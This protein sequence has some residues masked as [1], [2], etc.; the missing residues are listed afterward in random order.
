MLISL[1]ISGAWAS[2][3][4]PGEIASYLGVPCTPVCTVCHA[5]NS[6]GSGT[7]TQAFGVAMEDRGL[8]GGSNN[9][10]LT[11][12]L[13]QMTADAVDSDGDGTIDT[14][15]LVGGVDPNTGIAF[16]DV[17]SP[18]YGCT[19]APV[20]SAAAGL[21]GALLGLATTLTLRRR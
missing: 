16:C 17:V 8:T 18:I 19:T 14:D 13:D 12:A 4:Y 21:V 1:M 3:G 15:D 5:T 11:D 6:G 9:T 20:G 7:V 10:S 2:T